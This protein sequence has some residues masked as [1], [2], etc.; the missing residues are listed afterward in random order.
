[1]RED[2]ILESESD[3]HSSTIVREPAD[4]ELKSNVK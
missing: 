1:L 2:R 3:M 4:L